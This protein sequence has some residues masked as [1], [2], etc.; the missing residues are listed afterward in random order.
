MTTRLT[1]YDTDARL[2]SQ[3]RPLPSQ[4]LVP[5][6]GVDPSS[7][8]RPDPDSVALVDVSGDRGRTVFA[9]VGNKCNDGSPGY[10]LSVSRYDENTAVEIDGDR[11]LVLDEDTLAG[12]NTLVKLA[13]QGT[14]VESNAWH[15]V[16]GTIKKIQGARP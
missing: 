11:V 4:P 3:P 15:L 2:E 10:L 8:D 12:L 1:P 14:A 6:V 7:F 5:L 9:L 13:E 16:Q